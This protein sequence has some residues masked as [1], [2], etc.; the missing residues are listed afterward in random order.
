MVSANVNSGRSGWSVEASLVSK[1]TVNPIRRIVDTMKIVPHPEKQMIA[2]SIGDPTIFG[3]LECPESAIDSVI[4]NVKG[5]KANGYPHAAGYE[6]ARDAVARLYTH[7]DAPLTKDDVI[8]ASGCSG[9]LDLVI[10][11]IADEG[12]NILVPL[13][14]FSLYQTL[15]ESKGMHVKSYNLMPDRQWE[16]DLKHMES[17]IDSKTKAILINNPSN[18]CGSVFSHQHLLDIL[19]VAERNFLPIIS[20]EIYADMVFAPNEFIPLA[21]LSKNVP[22]LTVGGLAK[23][24]LVPG[25]RIGWV[26]IQDKNGVFEKEVRAALFN[27]TQLILGSNSLIQKCLPAILHETDQAFYDST[28]SVLEENAKF[29]YER[30]ANVPGLK[31]VMPQGAMYM[32]VGIDIEKFPGMNDDMDFTQRLISEQSVF[33][34]PGKCFKYPNYFRIV[35]TAPKDKLAVAYDRIAEFCAQ[36]IQA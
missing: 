3:N 29:S 33:C 10:S 30:L 26:L 4:K 27:L 15:A 8:L 13:P 14:G 19:E 11:A 5:G 1:R 6:D 25:W 35:F 24:W 23:R 9:A 34:L 32:M 16:C 21:P 31:P 7:S 12:D 2:L 17:L 22:I 28:L 18:P 36:H 20:D